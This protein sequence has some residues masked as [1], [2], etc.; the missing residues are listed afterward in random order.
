MTLLIELKCM[1]P[2]IDERLQAEGRWIHSMASATSESHQIMENGGISVLMKGIKKAASM[3]MKQ[4]SIRTLVNI[5]Q[6]RG[7]YYTDSHFFSKCIRH[8]IFCQRQGIVISFIARNIAII[9]SAL[10]DESSLFDCFEYGACI[11]NYW[12][13]SY[14]VKNQ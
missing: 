11:L 2:F 6:N 3:K 9:D 12:A 13:I 14:F 8:F 7:G 5:V 1:I 4:Y 10:S